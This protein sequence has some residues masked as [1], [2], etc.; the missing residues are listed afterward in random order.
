[1]STA[2][3]AVVLYITLRSGLYDLAPRNCGF[4]IE[5]NRQDSIVWRF[6]VTHATVY[7]ASGPAA[8]PGAVVLGQPGPT[9]GQA[10]G[11]AAAAYRLARW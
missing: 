5:E 6:L 3:A 10:S 7:H 2:V 11:L 4:T 1:M 9:A 8:V